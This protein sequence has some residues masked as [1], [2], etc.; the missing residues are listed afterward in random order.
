[1]RKYRTLIVITV[2]AIAGCGAAEE[3]GGLGQPCLPDG[4]CNAGLECN[5]NNICEQKAGEPTFTAIFQSSTFSNCSGCHAPG[6]PG[7][8]DGTE[9]TQ[10]WT[11]RN[12]AFQGLQG[13]ASGLIGNFEGCN[14]VPFLGSGPDDSLIVAVFD[15]TVRAAFSL[16]SHPDCT[17]DSISDM[18]LKLPSDIS[19]GELTLLKDWITAG[20]PNN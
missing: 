14:G 3:E 18:N 20:A 12:S 10:D 2:L 11:D 1:M 4:T 5:A 7:F 19:S 9:T 15:E 8:V 6:A 13:T 17:V 16:A